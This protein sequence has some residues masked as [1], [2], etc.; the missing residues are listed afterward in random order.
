MLTHKQIKQNLTL[1]QKKIVDT[2]SENIQVKGYPPSMREI[3]DAVGLASLSSVTHQ[4]VQLEKLGVI[5][6]DPKKPRTIE[7]LFP[8][9]NQE[10]VEEN[11]FDATQMVR[12]PLVGD[13]AAGNPLLAEQKVENSFS[14]PRDLVGFGE[15]FMLKVFGDS[16]VDAAICAGDFVVVRKQNVAENGDIVAAL[17]GEEATVKVFKKNDNHVWL[18]PRNSSYE[19]ILGDNAKIMGKVVSVLRSIF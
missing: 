8:V 14:L 10:S 4:L 13:I 19:P 11:R 3:G 18:L 1:R 5:R 17:L 2:I 6:R 12:V 16:M 15:L 9:V 7:V